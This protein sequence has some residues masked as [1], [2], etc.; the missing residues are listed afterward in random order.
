[1]RSL[2]TASIRVL[3][4]KFVD[5]FEELAS[6]TYR[7]FGL[8]ADLGEWVGFAMVNTQHILACIY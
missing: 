3:L 5:S 4:R 2:T 6:K 7:G 1:M 8:R